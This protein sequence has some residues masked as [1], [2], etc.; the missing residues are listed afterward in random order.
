MTSEASPFRAIPA[1]QWV[2][3]NRSGFAVWD[4]LPASPG[5]ALVVPFRQISSWWETVA[6]ERADLWEPVKKFV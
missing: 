5:H 3:Q 6:D 2:A 4:A 1:E